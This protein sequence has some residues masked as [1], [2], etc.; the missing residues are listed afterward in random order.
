[1][2]SLHF[3]LILILLISD[4]SIPILSV[5]LATESIDPSVKIFLFL[6]DSIDHWSQKKISQI[7]SNHTHV[8]NSSY[9]WFIFNLTTKYRYAQII[10]YSVHIWD[11]A[12]H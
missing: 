5:M 7:K 9:A 1:M 3:I 8:T 4:R 11:L 12:L 10:Y 2:I 6:I